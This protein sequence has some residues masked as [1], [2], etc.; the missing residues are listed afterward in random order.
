MLINHNFYIA[1]TGN[2]NWINKDENNIRLTFQRKND[3]YIY[4]LNKYAFYIWVNLNGDITLKTLFVKLSKKFHISDNLK[5]EI[6]NLLTDF[7]KRYLVEL[8]KYPRND[9]PSADKFYDFT[10]MKKV[11]S[12]KIKLIIHK[13]NNDTS[14]LYDEK[15]WHYIHNPVSK[16]RPF[17]P[18]RVFIDITYRCNSHCKHCY[19]ASSEKNNK[20]NEDPEKIH[21]IIDRLADAGIS[22]IAFIGGEP[23]VVKELFDY[24]DHAYKRGMPVTIYTNGTIGFIPNIEKIK[25]YN[26]RFSISLEGSNAKINDSIRFKGSFDKVMNTIKVGVANNVPI[27]VSF[28]VNRKNIKDLPKVYNLVKKLGV[29]AFYMRVFVKVGYGGEFHERELGLNYLQ[30]NLVKLFFYWK[31]FLAL[32]RKAKIVFEIPPQFSCPAKN[33]PNIGPNGDIHFCNSFSKN[34]T[35]GNILEEDFLKIW[36]SEKAKQYFDLSKIKEPCKSCVFSP[37]CKKGCRSE[38]YDKTGDFFEW[39]I[40][41]TRGKILKKI[42][43]IFRK[44]TRKNTYL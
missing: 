39:N 22:N 43:T 4:N 23:F 42:N 10:N 2:T 40:Y 6:L 26:I 15:I 18:R 41:C 21:K 8:S 28:T 34:I 14:L 36:H 32:F 17:Y 20:Y 11:R 30:L 27:K 24:V 38:V 12:P 16:Y 35:F 29:K 19:I 31:Q 3:L 13:A 5:K 44:F 37:I 7:R 25:K 33:F 9:I 1:R